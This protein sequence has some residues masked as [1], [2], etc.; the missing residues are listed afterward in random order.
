VR[1]GN[2]GVHAGLTI[3]VLHAFAANLID[4]VLMDICPTGPAP[5]D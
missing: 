5:N 2:V 4:P 1:S 3:S